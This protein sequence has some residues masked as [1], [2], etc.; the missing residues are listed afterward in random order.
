[1]KPVVR[2]IVAF[3]ARGFINGKTERRLRQW[4]L[5]HGVKPE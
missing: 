4:V 1:V 3:S 5:K 2:A